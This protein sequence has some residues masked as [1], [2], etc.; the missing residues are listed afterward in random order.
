MNPSTADH[1]APFDDGADPPTHSDDGVDLT[2]IRWFLTLS[3]AERL[4][5]LQ[6][7]IDSIRRLRG[8]EAD[9]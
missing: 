4:Q 9:V 1:D 5:F 8:D 2:L 6:A 7:N 3:P